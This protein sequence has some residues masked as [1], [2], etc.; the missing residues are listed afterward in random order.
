MGISSLQAF[1]ASIF[2]VEMTFTLNAEAAIS[3]KTLESIYC[4]VGCNNTTGNSNELYNIKLGIC[5]FYKRFLYQHR[6]FEP[7]SIHI[8]I[9]L[10][11]YGILY[12]TVVSKVVFIETL[13]WKLLY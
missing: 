4:A 10:Q 11:V 9:T 3:C 8:L 6:L 12:F 2:R 7:R 1:A 5:T 13:R